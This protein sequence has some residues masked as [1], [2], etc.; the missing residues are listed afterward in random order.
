MIRLGG[1]KPKSMGIFG[2]KR[3]GGWYYASSTGVA[4]TPPYSESVID[5][6]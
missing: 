6:V 2:K 3:E 1:L 5:T 4:S